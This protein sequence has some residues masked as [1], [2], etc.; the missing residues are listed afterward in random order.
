MAIRTAIQRGS[1]VYV[2]NEKNQQVLMLGVSGRPTDRLVGYT[3]ST[4]SIQRGNAIH[5]FDERGR[6]LS[7]HGTG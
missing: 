5:A 2:Y 7:V 6:L 3:E 1:A 4:V